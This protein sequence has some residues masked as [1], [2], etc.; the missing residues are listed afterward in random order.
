MPLHDIDLDTDEAA[1]DAPILTCLM[2]NQY[3]EGVPDAVR[4]QAGSDL[5]H[6]QADALRFQ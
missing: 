2:T 1:K 6:H 4:L 3:E 5:F